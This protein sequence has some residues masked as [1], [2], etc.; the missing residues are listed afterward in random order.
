MQN[1]LRVLSAKQRNTVFEVDLKTTG[2]VQQDL[3]TTLQTSDHKTQIPLKKL[4]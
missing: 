2:V 3:I 1:K 4:D